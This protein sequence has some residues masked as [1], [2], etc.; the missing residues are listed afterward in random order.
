M[1]K[2]IKYKYDSFPPDLSQ[3]LQKEFATM[4]QLAEGQ[5]LKN[6][7]ICNE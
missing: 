7:P 2:N 5:F 6:E 4:A 3:P 1:L